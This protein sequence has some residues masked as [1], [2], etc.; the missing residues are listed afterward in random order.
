MS[1]TVTNVTRNTGVII[2]GNLAGGLI[3]LFTA[4]LFVRYIGAGRYG[5]YAYIFAYLGFFS[6]F[7]DLGL[8]GIVVREISRRPEEAG[9]LLGSALSLKAALSLLVIA[10]AC[11]MIS[12]IPESYEIKL[13]TCIAAFSFL[14]SVGS[15]YRTVLQAFLR[16][17]YAIL[18]DLVVG[19]LRCLLYLWFIWARLGLVWFIC[20]EA[21][22]GLPSLLLSRFYAHRYVRPRWQVRLDIWK[23]LL[24]ESWPL[25]LSTVFVFFY[26]RIDQLML[27]HMKGPEAVGLYAPTVKL[28]EALNIVPHAFAVS[29]FPLFSHYFVSSQERLKRSFLLS[30]KV[31]MAFIIPIAVASGFFSQWVMARIFGAEFSVSAPAFTLLM[32]AEIFI[33]AGL[34]NNR[35]LIAVGRQRIDFLFTSSAA[36]INVLL[37]L[38]FIPRYSFMGAALASL[39]A[40]A[41]GPVLNCIIPGIR[42]YGL[43]MVRAMVRPFIASCLMA[44]TFSAAEGQGVFALVAAASVYLAALFVLRVFTREEMGLFLESI[45]R[46]VS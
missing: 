9:S 18:G 34:I 27:F 19:V 38:L 3:N 6:I 21:A 43:M 46:P 39:C 41:C 10:L 44:F 16:M 35:L 14:W 23:G 4:A 20:I 29:V 30:A 17:E 37:N 24:K 1:S 26:F 5:V 33:F 11:C 40:Y 25:A 31:M 22:V 13:L 7:V 36:L 32:W 8:N 2:L 12:L 28:T 45:R 15:L 42:S